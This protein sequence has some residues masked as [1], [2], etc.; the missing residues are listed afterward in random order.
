MLLVIVHYGDYEARD[1]STRLGHL[2]LWQIFLRLRWNV[3]VCA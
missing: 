2:C 3:C 1:L